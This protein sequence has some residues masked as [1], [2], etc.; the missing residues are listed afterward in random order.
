MT[1]AA[2]F[3]FSD[4][5]RLRKSGGCEPLDFDG[6]HL[7]SSHRF[8]IKLYRLTQITVVDI[9]INA[10][11]FGV[12]WFG[13]NILFDSLRLLFGGFTL[14]EEFFEKHFNYPYI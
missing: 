2:I 14:L 4:Y 13:F 3:K 8:G 7:R 1:K 11:T 12:N 6:T 5:K 9:Q 10:A